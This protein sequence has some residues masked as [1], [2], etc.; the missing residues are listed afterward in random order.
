M[1][2]LQPVPDDIVPLVGYREWSTR[3][4]PTER[5]PRLISVFHST[6]W[7]HDEPFSSLPP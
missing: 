6:T 4:E 2:E 3:T 5:P 7:P 1:L